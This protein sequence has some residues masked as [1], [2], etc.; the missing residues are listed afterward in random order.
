M[1]HPA[2][3]TH[4][5]HR[6]LREALSLAL[7]ATI[8]VVSLYPLS[9]WRDTGAHPLAFLSA[10][11][12]RFWTWFDLLSNV[13]AYAVL[14]AL[15]TL[16]LRHRAR[17]AAVLATTV[18]AILS[19]SLEAAQTYLPSRVPS[20]LDWLANTGGALMGAGLARLLPHRATLYRLGGRARPHE[21]AWYEQGPASGWVLVLLWLASQSLP[22]RM[23]FAT[24]RLGGVL[25]GLRPA[26][27]DGAPPL[28]HAWGSP[29]LSGY[30]VGVEAAVVV[31]AMLSVGS[32]ILT[33]VHTTPARLRALAAVTITA[34][35]LRSMATQKVYGSGAPLA[36]LTP[37]A[38]GGLVIGAVLL[39]GLVSLSQTTRARCAVV[40]T[41]VG[42]AL[43]HLSPNDAYFQTTAADIQWGPLR[44][45]RGLLSMIAAAWP[46]L[47]MIWLMKHAKSRAP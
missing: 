23:L 14:G 44:N 36:W 31:C 28:P 20:V 37:G 15:L 10:G 30:G 1:S 2:P 42:A 25:N 18:A 16:S 32:L 5:P 4:R 22:Q 34:C 33:L 7:M 39:Y 46:W 40:A 38:Q 29:L 3:P 26:A 13:L 6:A 47:T 19:L 8:T 21:P 11:L 9:G 17:A 45:L 27:W 41:T 35:A 43:L 12:P 24:G